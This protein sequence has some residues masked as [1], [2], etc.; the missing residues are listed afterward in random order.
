MGHEDNTTQRN[1]WLPD[2]VFPGFRPYM[3]KFFDGLSVISLAILAA[4][5]IGMSLSTEDSILLGRIHTPV[6]HQMRLAHYLP[7]S[8]E[9]QKDP[10]KIRLAPHKDFA[11]VYHCYLESKSLTY[12]Y[13]LYT[14]LCQESGSG[15][16]FQNRE[17]GQYMPAAPKEGVLYLNIGNLFER[18]S[19]RF[20]PFA[21]HRV[22]IPP[23][24]GSHDT[25]PGRLSIPHFTHIGLDE[26]IYPLHS[27][28]QADGNANY[29]PIK[30]SVLA[31]NLYNPVIKTEG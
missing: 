12:Y 30:Y 23:V 18:Y 3:V 25:I 11:S 10:N 29:E 2:D 4:L 26:L 19:N 13:S 14:L 16:E 9:H 1:I 17:T 5:M 20:Y 22:A 21:M 31:E 24:K 8:P 6:E 7:M 15:L 27:R 28:V